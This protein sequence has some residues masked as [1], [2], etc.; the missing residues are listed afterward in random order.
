[1][2]K[3]FMILLVAILAGMMVAPVSAQGPSSYESTV[4]V[5]NVSET[6]GTITL[7]FYNPDGSPAGDQTESIDPLET[8]YFETFSVDSGF[9]GSMVISSSVPL[10]SSSTIIG[11]DTSI[12][13][14]A[15]YVGV[16]AGATDIYIPL[17]MD[18]N[19]GY[20]TYFSIQNTGSSDVDV[21][22]SY[23]D[24]L[25]ASITDLAPGA[26][27]IIDNQ[28]EA[29]PSG[30]FSATLAADGPI[31]VAVV[32]WADGSYGEE[33]FAYNGYPSTQ[34]TEFPVI[35]MVNQNNYGFWTSIPVQNLGNVDTTVT[36]T[37][38]PTKEGEQCSETLLVPAGGLAEFGA[39][40]FVFP[41]QTP[42]CDCAFGETFVGTA[43]VTGNTAG[44]PLI[45]LTN[46]ST[47]IQEGY[48]KAGALMA[49]NPTSATSRV[50][51]PEAYQWFG[52]DNWWSS[53]TITNVSGSELEIGDVTCRGI[54][55]AEG[56]PVDFEWS[57]TEAIADKEG[58]IVDMYWDW[59]PLPVGFMGGVICESDSGEILGTLNN[60]GHNAP[61]L[62]DSFTLYEG[63]NIA[64]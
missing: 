21:T 19:Y 32:E 44:Q 39:Y 31:A 50:A 43:V 29:H 10:A 40:A 38:Y 11:S 56:S 42:G 22:I 1:M 61:A 51:F 57:N 63:I 12:M 62:L 60:L 9:E 14:F 48:Q 59:G 24:G 30:K 58:W 49:I 20:N 8:L 41:D 4:S 7:N 16:S 35:P 23:S 37:Y 25:S 47:T 13:N 34:G 46:Q 36:L 26:A 54:G 64:P 28:S 52:T 55:Q 5:T 33:L 53:I 2:R 17:L 45:G 6:A 18:E 27:E 3:F 15:S